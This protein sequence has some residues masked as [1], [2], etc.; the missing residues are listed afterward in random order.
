[1]KESE[2]EKE[3][4]DILDLEK[5]MEQV[6]RKL[7]YLIVASVFITLLL[8]AAMLYVLIYKAKHFMPSVSLSLSELSEESLKKVTQMITL[9]PGMSI[10]SQ[11]IS[12]NL[13]SLEVA[14][15][16]GIRKVIIYNYRENKIIS[17][18]I[19]R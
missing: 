11:A 8:I 10:I 15:K 6:R 14:E 13:I 3:K 1:M 9:S 16:N 4:A 7:L 2:S 12:G 5:N 17:L 19:F 18:L